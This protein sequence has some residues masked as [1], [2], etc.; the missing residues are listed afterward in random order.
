MLALHLQEA[1]FLVYS[2]GITCEAA[3]G[4][5]YAMT[6]DDERDGIVTDSA[7]DGLG[8]HLFLSILTGYHC[9]PILNLHTSC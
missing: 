5:R 1:L 6:R 7:P 8:R 2:S 3:A 4:S 9:G